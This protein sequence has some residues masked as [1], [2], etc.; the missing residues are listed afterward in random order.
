MAYDIGDIITFGHSNPTQPGHCNEARSF[1]SYN[2]FQVR[3][4]RKAIWSLGAEIHI[5]LDLY[6]VVPIKQSDQNWEYDSKI[7]CVAI[8]NGRVKCASTSIPCLMVSVAE[9]LIS[10]RKVKRK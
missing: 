10:R 1:K 5:T 3:E 2:G 9:L 8:Y 7:T 4:S 6:T